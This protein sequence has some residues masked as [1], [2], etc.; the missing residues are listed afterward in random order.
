MQIDIPSSIVPLIL[1]LPEQK[2]ISQLST[3]VLDELC[4]GVRK[5]CDMDEFRRSLLIQSL[6]SQPENLDIQEY[7]SDDFLSPFAHDYLLA[8]VNYPNLCYS[9]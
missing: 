9:L 5:I 3:E 1:S 2:L 8:Q 6:L 4:D 7:D